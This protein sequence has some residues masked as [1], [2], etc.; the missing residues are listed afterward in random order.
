MTLT[1][2]TGRLSVR[3]SGK[4]FTNEHVVAAVEDTTGWKGS[5]PLIVSAI[6]LTCALF[7]YGD[8]AGKVIF[9]LKSTLAA[10]I[11]L[12]SKLRM[13]LVLSQSAVGQKDAFVTR[14]RPNMQGHVSV[15]SASTSTPQDQ[16]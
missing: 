4:P 7:E 1:N 3:Y 6:V 16:S 10:M 15:G 14:Y 11:N 9:M 5:S 13:S 2:T 12:A 8:T